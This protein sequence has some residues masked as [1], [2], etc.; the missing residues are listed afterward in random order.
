MYGLIIHSSYVFSGLDFY[1]QFFVEFIFLI[2][3]SQDLMLLGGS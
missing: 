2:K 3:F 1:T